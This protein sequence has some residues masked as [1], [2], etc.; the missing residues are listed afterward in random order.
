MTGLLEKY[1]FVDLAQKAADVNAIPFQFNREAH[2][3][4]NGS[5]IQLFSRAVQ[6]I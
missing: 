3:D 6:L 5:G 1:L 4:C 2:K